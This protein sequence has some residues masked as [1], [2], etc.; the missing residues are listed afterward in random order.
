M[1]TT[2]VSREL[3]EPCLS[4]PDSSSEKAASEFTP[5]QHFFDSDHSELG[6]A[7]EEMSK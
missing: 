6:D 1:V 5:A 4:V 2:S 3:P 7:S